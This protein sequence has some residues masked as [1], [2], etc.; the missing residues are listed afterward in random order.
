MVFRAFIITICFLSFFKIE[1][2]FCDDQNQATGLVFEQALKNFETQKQ[3]EQELLITKLNFNSGYV[4]ENWINSAK[5]DKAAKLNT[6]LEQSWEKLSLSYPISPSHYEYYLR[7]YKYNLLKN[8]V[9]RTDSLNSPFKAIVIVNEELYVEKYHSP[10]ISDANPYFYT[11][12][13]NYTL[14][15]EYKNEKFTLVNSDSKIISIENDCP[16]E[17]KKFRL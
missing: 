4:I 2:S 17:I 5:K 14:N 9:I 1:N 15:F 13:T 11:V 10:N 7:G 3:K 16:D 8:D 6:R 12:S